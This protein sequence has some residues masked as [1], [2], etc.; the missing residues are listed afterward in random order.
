MCT[1]RRWDAIVCIS[2]RCNDSCTELCPEMC[3]MASLWMHWGQRACEARGDGEF[4]LMSAARLWGVYE[5]S[6]KRC[7]NP[8]DD[9]FRSLKILEKNSGRMQIIVILRSKTVKCQ[10]GCALVVVGTKLPQYEGPNHCQYFWLPV[11]ERRSHDW[12]VL[13]WS[14]SASLKCK[15]F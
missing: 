8:W 6:S 9:V 5:V 7:N 12:R 4:S 13:C 15:M 10:N 3:L 11:T 2:W 1:A 14:W